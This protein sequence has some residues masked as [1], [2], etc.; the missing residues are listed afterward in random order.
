MLANRPDIVREDYM[1]E[2]CVL[3]DDVPPFPDNQVRL[4]GGQQGA[5]HGCWGCGRGVMTILHGDMSPFPCNQP[6][7][8]N[9][10]RHDATAPWPLT[11]VSLPAL[12]LP[13]RPFR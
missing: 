2:L 12:P 6:L 8:V 11:S 13:S 3:Q 10:F 1:N 4:L 7:A 9:N 5:G